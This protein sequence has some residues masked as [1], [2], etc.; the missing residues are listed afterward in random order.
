MNQQIQTLNNT[1]SNN[2]HLITCKVHPSLSSTN[3]WNSML[4]IKTLSEFSDNNTT[5]PKR[6]SILAGCAFFPPKLLDVEQSSL[7][8]IN[9]Y[10]WSILYSRSDYIAVQINIF[11]R[12]INVYLYMEVLSFFVFFFIYFLVLTGSAIGHT[13]WL[14]SW[15]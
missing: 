6:I 5:K 11:T 13:T 9:I 1:S 8:L 7:I 4:H 10:S 15:F 3:R 2:D 14:V 12:Q